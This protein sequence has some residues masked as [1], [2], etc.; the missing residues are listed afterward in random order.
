MQ[1]LEPRVTAG[2]VPIAAG[3]RFASRRAGIVGLS[4]LGHPRSEGG[5]E[6]IEIRTAAF[7]GFGVW[8]VSPPALVVFHSVAATQA[9]ILHGS[10]TA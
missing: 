4:N 1:N 9:R 2:N 10:P 6:M 5:W 7:S 3:A 8:H